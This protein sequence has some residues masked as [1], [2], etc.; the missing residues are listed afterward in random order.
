MDRQWEGERGRRGRG[1]NRWTQRKRDRR[2][3][4]EEGNGEDGETLGGIN[5]KGGKSE[6]KKER[7]DIWIDNK[8]RTKRRGKIIGKKKEKKRRQGKRRETDG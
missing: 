3:G 2:K 4:R 7:R 1:K 5:A 8:G 6:I